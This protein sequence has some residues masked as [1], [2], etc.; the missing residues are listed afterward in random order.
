MNRADHANAEQF[1]QTML[2]ALKPKIRRV[3]YR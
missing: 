3:F 1:P 2:H